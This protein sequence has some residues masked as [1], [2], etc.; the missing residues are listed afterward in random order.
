MFLKM[1]TRNI[2]SFIID[3]VSQ[4]HEKDKLILIDN[5]PMCKFRKIKHFYNPNLSGE[6]MFLNIASVKTVYF[7]IYRRQESFP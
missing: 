4:V 6:L 3:P 1:N 5:N 2:K 7:K